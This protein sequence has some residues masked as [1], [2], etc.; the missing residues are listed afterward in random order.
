MSARP[1]A[2]ATPAGEEFIPTRKTLLNR[3]Q[4]ASDDES[5][6]A[7]FDTY[8]KLIYGVALRAG[9]SPADAEDVVQ[10]TVIS[11]AKNIGQFRYD[12]QK[13]SFKTW[14]MVVT[15]SRIA[16]QF[17]RLSRAPHPAAA[18]ESDALENIPDMRAD[19]LEALWNEEWEKNIMD[20]AIAKTRSLVDPEHFQ[21]FDFYVLR[22][23]PV[24]KVASTFRVNVASVYLTKHRVAKV[25]RKQIQLLEERS[26]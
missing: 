2:N 1:N 23:W 12:P 22:G 19:A 10:E 16:N 6:R 26:W 21:I 24:S 3:L 25:V 8:W 13:C 11:V 14:L 18:D 5:W 7:F 20:A 15:R 9:L 17:R 4:S